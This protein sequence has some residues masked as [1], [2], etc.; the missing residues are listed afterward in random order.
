MDAHLDWKLPYNADNIRGMLTDNKTSHVEVIDLHTN[1]CR[2]TKTS[3]IVESPKGVW[4]AWRLN[5]NNSAKMAIAM[6]TDDKDTCDE[7]I[8]HQ[9]D[10]MSPILNINAEN[11]ENVRV[12]GVTDILCESAP[13]AIYNIK[14]LVSGKKR[15]HPGPSAYVRVRTDGY[16]Q[17][18][19]SSFADHTSS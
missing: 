4:A 13:A 10:R 11:V 9:K 7:L 2:G 8:K 12:P 6:D 19:K 14:W 17:Y 16:E 1:S 18:M 3:F 15:T 5:P